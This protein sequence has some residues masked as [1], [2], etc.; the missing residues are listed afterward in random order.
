MNQKIQVLESKFVVI[1]GIYEKW[2][3]FFSNKFI[4][5]RS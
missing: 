2:K 1:K 5:F 4:Y 3:R